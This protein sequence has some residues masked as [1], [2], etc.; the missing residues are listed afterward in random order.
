MALR[1]NDLLGLA[2]AR[3]AQP[4]K[5]GEK[6]ERLKQARARNGGMTED[7]LSN[8]RHIKL[9]GDW[10]RVFGV[11]DPCESGSSVLAKGAHRLALCKHCARCELD[12]PFEYV[13]LYQARQASARLQ[14]EGRGYEKAS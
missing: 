14:C 10:L 8:E 11:K 6:A 2:S 5:L 3:T 7:L 13:N 4:T 1:L 12:L 9:P